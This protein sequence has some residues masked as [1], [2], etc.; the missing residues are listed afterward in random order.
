VLQAVQAQIRSSCP[1]FPSRRFSKD[2]LRN[3]HNILQRANQSAK[4]RNLISLVNCNE[5]QN[6]HVFVYV[7]PKT[8]WQFENITFMESPHEQHH[9]PLDSLMQHDPM[10]SPKRTEGFDTLLCAHHTP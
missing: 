7:T 2:A 1:M 9:R 8:Y 6:C 3:Q 5:K 4:I 10:S